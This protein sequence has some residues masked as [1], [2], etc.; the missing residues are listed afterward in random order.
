MARDLKNE[1][2]NA[3]VTFI[4]RGADYKLTWDK[5][6]SNE[7]NKIAW[8]SIVGNIEIMSLWIYPRPNAA[9]G[10]VTIEWKDGLLFLAVLVDPE[11]YGA[12]LEADIRR[13]YDF[14]Q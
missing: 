6:P 12:G 8:E 2:Q 14:Q 13:K 9:F 7:T 3:K 10:E 5:V 1:D 11:A 4:I